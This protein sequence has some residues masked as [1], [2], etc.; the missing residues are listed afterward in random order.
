MTNLIYYYASGPTGQ[1][2]TTNTLFSVGD[3]WV[4]PA[5]APVI[6]TASSGKGGK[7]WSSKLPT[8]VNIPY[9]SGGQGNPPP[10]TAS[11]TPISVTAT[12]GNAVNIVV[13]SA[14]GGGAIYS[15]DATTPTAHK[16]TTSAAL[17]A[18]LSLTYAYSII[19]VTGDS[20]TN[21]NPNWLTA[22]S[23]GSVNQTQVTL[24]GTPTTLPTVDTTYTLTFTD[25]SRQTASSTFVI[26]ATT[27]PSLPKP[28]ATGTTT[29]YSF[30]QNIAV[31][32]FTPVTGSGGTAPLTYSIVSPSPSLPNGL[33]INSS[34]GQISGT[35][36]VAAAATTITVTV[37]DANL[38]TATATFS[39]SVIAVVPFSVVSA[40]TTPL[41]FPVNSAI[42]AFSPATVTGGIAPYSYSFVPSLPSG[43]TSNAQG[44]ISGTPTVTSSA[45]NYQ[46]T[47]TD[48]LKETGSATFNLTITASKLI[49]TQSPTA[50]V[51]ETN[52]VLI[53]PYTPVTASGG[54]SPYSFSIANSSSTDLKTVVPGLAYSTSTGQITGTPT[55]TLSSTIFTV[56]VTDSSSVPQTAT[57]TFTMTVNALP[58]LTTAVA[59]PAVT[60]T[61][62]LA[63]TA[64]T[65][66]TAAGGYGSYSFS[67]ANSSGVDLATAVSGLA[68]SKTTGQ[69]TGTPTASSPS[70]SYTVTVTD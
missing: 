51:T 35:P 34:T 29:S 66:V 23:T 14:Y 8:G 3:Y 42:T 58:A 49:A 17:P 67:I 27:T 45:T 50:S 54:Q 28:T 33:A 61:S 63:L 59:Q 37:T 64:V 13:G 4:S 65:P 36:T 57:A 1:P 56:T 68:Y 32:A 6:L 7:T 41:A 21:N 26:K 2:P 43:L 12:V 15:T 40:Q 9:V 39:L 44:Q 20:S 24:T 25:G 10:V 55:S 18:G 60:G 16:V 53:S 62:N 69:I 46:V 11:Q 52:G 38:Q 31:T 48:S 5:N 19:T 70:P 47:V 30:Y 22:G